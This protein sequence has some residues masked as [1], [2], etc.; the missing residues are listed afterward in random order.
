MCGPGD[1]DA[2]RDL[3]RVFDAYRP[4]TDYYERYWPDHP[5]IG[6][7]QWLSEQWRRP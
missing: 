4:L 7:D 5:R 6:A 3:R 1:G 2:V